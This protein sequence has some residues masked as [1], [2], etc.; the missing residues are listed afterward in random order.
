[1]TKVAGERCQRT[2]DGPLLV[3]RAPGISLTSGP[4]HSP[5]GVGTRPDS[6]TVTGH[7]ESP[8]GAILQVYNCR[9]RDL[10]FHFDQLRKNQ[11]M[12]NEHH[13]IPG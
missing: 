5:R 13:L 12:T 2:P 1:M 4:V 9:T 7:F 3:Q 10:V 11:S 8:T 6:I